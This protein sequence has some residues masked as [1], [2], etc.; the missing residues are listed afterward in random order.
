MPDLA[1]DTEERTGARVTSRLCRL[2]FLGHMSC[3]A[4]LES[5]GNHGS[6]LS[7]SWCCARLSLHFPGA[8]FFALGAGVHSA[9]SRLKILT[10]FF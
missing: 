5:T 6:V 4:V 7:P 1:G 9:S 8:V 2:L 10:L 3:L